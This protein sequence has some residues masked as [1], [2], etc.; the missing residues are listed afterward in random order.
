MSENRN[1]LLWQWTK[2][3]LV[4]G[5]FLC[6]L[7]RPLCLVSIKPNW[8]V[9]LVCY[10]T[11]KYQKE[12]EQSM[13]C[14]EWKIVFQRGHRESLG[15]HGWVPASKHGA[16]TV[17]DSCRQAAQSQTQEKEAE[18]NNITPFPL[19]YVLKDFRGCLSAC[20]LISGSTTKRVC[21]GFL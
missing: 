11:P 6:L 12:S 10:Q 9:N 16:R 1:L 17:D 18:P 2:D 14:I 5:T 13:V 15:P 3:G 8:V 20:S 19:F 7:L 4:S 21:S